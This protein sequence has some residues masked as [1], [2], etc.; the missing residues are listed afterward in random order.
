MEANT[1]DQ[2]NELVIFVRRP[3]VP[4]SSAQLTT[5]QTRPTECT[6]V[7]P[8]S[9]EVDSASRS[10]VHFQS[11]GAW[12]PINRVFWRTAQRSDPHAACGGRKPI[13]SPGSFALGQSSTRGIPD[14]E[15]LIAHPPYPE[16]TTASD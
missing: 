14:A 16:Y 15:Y 4:C 5:S 12:T 13:A 7:V 1:P 6:S 8:G 3:L 9:A 10:A 2:A 11:C